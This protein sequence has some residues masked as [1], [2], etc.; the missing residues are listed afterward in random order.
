MF[1]FLL[2][3]LNLEVSSSRLD[4]DD[5]MKGKD[6]DFQ[7]RISISLS[8]SARELTFSGIHVPAQL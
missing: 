4:D 5:E 7:G 8:T 2:W 1:R 6:G 3:R